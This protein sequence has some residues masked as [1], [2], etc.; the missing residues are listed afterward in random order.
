[1]KRPSVKNRKRPIPLPKDVIIANRAEVRR[2]L[3]P[4]PELADLLPAV[5][6]RT[7]QEFGPAAELELLVNH[8]PEIYD[9]FLILYVRLPS[10]GPG[11]MARLDSVWLSFEDALSATEG[12]LII[13]S[14]CRR[15][16]AKHGV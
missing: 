16:K 1:M 9:P 3:E 14:D 8:D 10:Y 6:E 15:L 5:V 7:R 2:Y 13:T 4:Y 11:L 12:W